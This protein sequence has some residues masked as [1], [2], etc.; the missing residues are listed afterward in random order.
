MKH[1]RVSF[2][3]AG[4]AL[5]APERSAEV[6]RRLNTVDARCFC[7]AG[8]ALGGPQSHS[9]WQV[10]HLEHLRLMASAARDAPPER[11][12]RR[13][14]SAVD[15]GCVCVADAALGGPQSHSAWQV[16]HLG[17]PPSHGPPSH[18]RCS[19]WSTSREVRGS[20]AMIECCGCQLRLQGRCSTWSTS[21]FCVA[22]AARG[23]PPERSAGARRRLS[24]GRR[25]HLRGRRSTWSTSVEHLSLILRGWCSTRSTSVSFCVAALVCS[26]SCSTI[27]PFCTS[28]HHH[29]HNTIYTAPSTLHHQAQ[30]HQHTPST[31]HH[32]HNI[33]NTTSSKH[34]HLHNTIYTTPSTQHHPHNTIYTYLHYIITYWQVQHLEHCHLTPSALFLLIPLLLF[35]VVACSLFCFVDLF[36]TWMSVRRHC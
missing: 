34:H 18:G 36:H 30:H 22:G 29:L 21:A 17:A 19:K 23:A 11:S 12:V 3:V 13:R 7:V 6:R 31:L 33:I 14:L 5:G 20:P 25:L 24:T 10:Q 35:F 26:S 9:A 4:A 15:A 28:T 8:A 2:C 27:L 1:L 16:Q 32:Q